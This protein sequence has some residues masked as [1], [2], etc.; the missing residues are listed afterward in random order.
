MACRPNVMPDGITRHCMEISRKH[1]AYRSIQKPLD[2]SGR[3]AGQYYLP[4]YGEQAA[5]EE[6]VPPFAPEGCPQDKLGHLIKDE[7]NDND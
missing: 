2:L 1:K 6:V 5:S 3:R 7:M 4:G